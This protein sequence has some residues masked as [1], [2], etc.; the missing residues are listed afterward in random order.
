LALIDPLGKI[1]WHIELDPWGNC[2]RE[3][4][5]SHL[6]QPIRMQGQHLDEESGLFYNRHRYYDP[7]LGRYI[8]RDPIGLMG[9]MNSYLYSG[10]PNHW[11]D[12]LG[13][14]KISSGRNRTGVRQP[15]LFD[16]QVP[17]AELDTQTAGMLQLPDYGSGGLVAGKK[18]WQSAAQ[19][20]SPHDYTQYCNQ[21]S[22]MNLTCSRKDREPGRDVK[23]PGDYIPNDFP[24]KTSELPEGYSCDMPYYFLDIQGAGSAA[25]ADTG[26]LAD[27]LKN[28]IQKRRGMRK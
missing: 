20:F 24:W 1:D 2:I 26:D 14:Q 25:T 16:H 5:P 9:G 3:Y 13:L 28:M 19:Q 8:S 23:V 21:W 27:L 17:Q 10:D 15:A 11:F 4:N 12:P 7:A 18:P 22:K 6:H